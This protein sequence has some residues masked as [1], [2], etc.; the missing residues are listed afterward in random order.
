MR[1]TEENR[2]RRVRWADLLALPL[3]RPLTLQQVQT[4]IDRW[5]RTAGLL[6]GSELPNAAQLTSRRQPGFHRGRPSRRAGRYFQTANPTAINDGFSSV[7]VE[8]VSDVNGTRAAV[9]EAAHQ[10]GVCAHVKVQLDQ[11]AVL[12]RNAF[13]ASLAIDNSGAKPLEG[14][15]VT[16]DIRDQVGNIATPLFAIAPPVLTG[17]G[18]ISGGSTIAAGANASA[19]WTLV[20]GDEAA[21]DGPVTYI[22]KGTLSYR[23]DGVQVEM[24]M[25]PSPIEVRPN[26]S[27]RLKYFWSRD[28]YA[29]DPFTPDIEPSEPFAVGLM[30]TNVGAGIANDVRITTAQPKIVDNDKGLAINFNLI[31]AQVNAQPMS[32]SL[33]VDLGNINPGADRRR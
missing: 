6:V 33:D 15:A 28:V 29:D 5:N 10:A 23:L 30:M 21:P 32:P 16:L 13:K 24:P 7:F 9:D 12:S 27:L 3:P 22:V 8:L 4:F 31:G 26:P 14:L 19:V 18:D 1:A 2:V 17:I 20:P 11:Q 25:L